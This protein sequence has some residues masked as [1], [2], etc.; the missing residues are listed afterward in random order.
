MRGSLRDAVKN[1][2]EETTMKNVPI[3]N[4]GASNEEMESEIG[5]YAK[6]WARKV[7]SEILTFGQGLTQKVKV[8][9]N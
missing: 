1:V 6:N 2:F 9:I 4:F 8:K 3:A 5:I 7:L